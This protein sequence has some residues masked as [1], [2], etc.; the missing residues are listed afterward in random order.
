MKISK[1]LPK[2]LVGK[3]LI[4]IG[5][6]ILVLVVI[7]A[8]FIKRREGFAKSRSLAKDYKTETDFKKTDLYN[9]F[10]NACQIY[11]TKEVTLGKLTENGVDYVS[12]VYC[13]G[14]GYAPTDD[15]R[16]LKKFQ[17]DVKVNDLKGR[18]G[19]DICENVLTTLYPG[20]FYDG[21]YCSIECKCN[22]PNNSPVR[23]QLSINTSLI[24]EYPSTIK[25]QS[26]LQSYINCPNSSTCR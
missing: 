21:Q 5:A 26:Y 8:F 19:K 25:L 20:T 22:D 3:K 16:G 2:A 6:V 24:D 11:A 1:F 7:Y 4:C 23:K 14:K 18:T 9:K 15:I 12:T 10:N 17:G 13:D